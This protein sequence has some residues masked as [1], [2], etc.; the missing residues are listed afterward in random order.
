[1]GDWMSALARIEALEDAAFDEVLVAEMQAH[2]AGARARDLRF[3][4]PSFKEYDSQEIK[5][6]GKNAFPAFSITGAA[7]ALDCDHC[8]AKIL[9]PMIPATR[10]E[11]LDRKVRDLVL[12]QGLQGFLLSGGSNRRNEIRYER[13]YPVIER[14]KRDFPGMRIA[15]HTAL[16]DAAGAKRMEAA[17]VDT[18]MMDVIGAEETIREVYHLDRPVEDFEATLAALSATGMEISPHIVIGLH[19]GR[20]K[21]EARA[22]EIVARYPTKALVLVVVMPFYAT[23]GTFATVPPADVGRIFLRAREVLPDRDLLLGCA[24]PAGM[25]KRVTDAYAVMAGL[26]GIAFPAEGAVG[27]AQM[28]GRRWD[29]AHACCSIKLGTGA[30]LRA[31][32]AA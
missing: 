23:P 29:Q 32:C 3:S 14:L 15:I 24:R 12:L 26:D 5:G 11:D 18:A 25:H 10:P 6:C 27:V 1:M 16:T 19:Y 9:E 28:V 21:G 7:C 31:G 17:G 4:T 22:L 2:A 20:L 13:F 8:R 30:S